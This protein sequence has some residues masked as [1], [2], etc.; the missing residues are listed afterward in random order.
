MNDRCPVLYCIYD[1]DYYTRAE[2]RHP[3][4][5]DPRRR[6]VRVEPRHFRAL[7]HAINCNA[8]ILLQ[9][10]EFQSPAWRSPHETVGVEGGGKLCVDST[11]R[12][13]AVVLL[14]PMM[15]KDTGK[16]TITAY[17]YTCIYVYKGSDRKQMDYLIGCF[18]KSN[19]MD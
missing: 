13:G 19:Q 9:P 1:E 10:M 17:S 11:G 2:H 5:H 18:R 8:R 16:N 12:Y 14:S 15:G 7:C 3:T 4:T 6:H